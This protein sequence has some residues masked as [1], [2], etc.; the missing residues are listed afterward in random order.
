MIQLETIKQNKMHRIMLT[1]ARVRDNAAI[2]R[3]YIDIVNVHVN[4]KQRKTKK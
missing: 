4:V 2:D 1:C 3:K